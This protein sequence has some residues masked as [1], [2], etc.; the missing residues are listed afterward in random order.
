MV[1]STENLRDME[2]SRHLHIR[3]AGIS[4]NPPALQAWLKSVTHWATEHYFHKITEKHIFSGHYSFTSSALFPSQACEVCR[5]SP[6]LLC[7]VPLGGLVA[8]LREASLPFTGDAMRWEH[9]KPEG[10]ASV[11]SS[12][13]SHLWLQVWK[14]HMCLSRPCFS[15][16]NCD[17]TFKPHRRCLCKR[18]ERNQSSFSVPRVLTSA[19]YPISGA[20][21]GDH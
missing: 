14:R 17:N 10:D 21:Y 7:A 3:R 4:H 6:D 20:W 2:T 11:R 19:S 9:R 1:L 5:H 13:E 18:R 12:L 8:R 15:L 16:L